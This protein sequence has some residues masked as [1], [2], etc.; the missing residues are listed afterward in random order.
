[1]IEIKKDIIFF[2][3]SGGGVTF[4]GGE[5]LLQ[6]EFLTALLNECKKEELHTAVDT[7][8]YES[9]DLIKKLQKKVDLYLYDLKYIDE[10]QHK[11]FTGVSNKKILT[12]LEFLDSTN[13][14]VFVRVP[15][16][17]EY[18]DKEK[19]I[20]QIGSY[21]SSLT[22]IQ[23]VDILPYN[24]FGEQKYYRLNREF[25]LGEIGQIQ[26]QSDNQLQKIKELIK[27]HIFT[28][29]IRQTLSLNSGM[30]L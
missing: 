21:I 12:N 27:P 1:M 7:T 19:N 6:A 8:G 10:A 9:L 17:P 26:T 30:I 15:L 4:S 23:H 20:H 28:E 22:N 11:Q 5:P 18:T 14:S 25:K 24:R 2:D 16:I 3:E 13:Q 29:L